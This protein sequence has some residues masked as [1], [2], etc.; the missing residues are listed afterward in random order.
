MMA[1]LGNCT[2]C[3]KVF[4]KTVRDICLEC[5]RKE[6]EDFQKVYRFLQNRKNREATIHEIV[7]AT[8]VDEDTIIKFLKQK[9]LRPSEF[10]KLG[11][12]CEICGKNIVQGRLCEDCAK[13]IQSE[14]KIHDEMQKLEEERKKHEESVYYTFGKDKDSR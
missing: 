13:H 10:P 1:E 4:A 11:Y 7:E 6:E 3:G 2:R 12:P 5:Y 8:G 14:A 9:R